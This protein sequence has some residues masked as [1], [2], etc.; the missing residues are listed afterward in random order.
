MPSRPTA[1]SSSTTCPARRGYWSARAPGTP[2]SSP[3]CA[4]R[5]AVLFQDWGSVLEPV[6]LLVDDSRTPGRVETELR[7][8]YATDYQVITTGSVK[9]AL[10]V[11]RQ[12]R[13]EG[14]QVSLVLADQRLLSGTTGTELLARV[15]QFYSAARPTLLLPLA[16]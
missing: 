14:R 1:T 12:L 2:A 16:E 5:I 3:R 15:R 8:R 13:D 7:K 4:A 11:L 9:E 6:L 10:D